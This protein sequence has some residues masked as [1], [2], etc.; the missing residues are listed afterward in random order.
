MVVDLIK[1]SQPDINISEK[2][3]RSLFD[4]TTCETHFLFKGIF[5]DQ[6]NGV[7][8]GSPL[9]SVLANLFMRHYEKEWSRNYDR[10]SPSYYKQYV[11]DIVSVF[12][13]YNE[14]KEFF[15]YLNSRDPNVK[16]TMEKKINKVIPSLDVL[17]D[18]RNNILNTMV[19]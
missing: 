14:T 6:I 1:T 13:W 19:A 5:Y 15:S 4:L 3:L 11:D 16:F 18:N 17:I 9:A 8:I 10:V 12:N 7:G 2:D